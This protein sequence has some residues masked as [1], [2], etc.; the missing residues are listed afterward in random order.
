MPVS[1]AREA[2]FDILMRIEAT[3]AYASELLH[4]ARVEKLSPADHGLLTELVM[5]VLRWRSLLDK[6]IE[7]SGHNSPLPAKPATSGAPPSRKIPIQVAK[8]DGEVLTALRLGAYQLLFLDRVPKHAAVNESVELVK[9]A[10]KRSAAGLVNAVLRKLANS[11]LAQNRREVRH[12][13]ELYVAAHPPWL[14]D[15]WE[16]IYGQAVTSKICEHDQ[17]PPATVLRIIPY[18]SSGERNSNSGVEGIQLAPGRLLTQANIVISGVISES[19]VFR[20]HRMIIQDEASQLVALLVGTGNAVLDCCA[21]PGGKTRLLA[22]RNPDANVVALELH[23]HRAALLKRLIC[24]SNVQIVAADARRMP[25]TKRFARVLVDAPCSGTGTLARNPEIKWRLKPD[26]ITRMQA[27]QLELLTSAMDRVSMGGRLLYST[28][29]LEPEE[30]QQVIERA[31]S[32]DPSFKLLD[33]RKELEVLRG[34][35]ELTWKDLDS[36]IQGPYLRT[37]PGV[38]PCDGFFAAI[39]EKS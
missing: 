24:N 38:H 5:G 29:S 15:R 16:R 23:P 31:L 6:E 22:E 12:P 37:I 21:A 11:Q 13:N 33:C 20:D 25:L 36:V 2:A 9:R 8:L 4:S 19:T 34:Q 35:G 14:V 30:N 18:Q 39:L 3:D 26:D 10:R 17:S 27:Y 1:A 28:C 7:S 32:L